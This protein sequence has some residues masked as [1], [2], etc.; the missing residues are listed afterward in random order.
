[1][2]NSELEQLQL[3]TE[4]DELI[5]RMSN[6]ADQ[7]TAWDPQRHC[8]TLI[9]RLLSRVE[10]LRIRL[11]APLLVAT[12]GGTGTGKSALVN[13]L[14]GQVCTPSGHERPTTTQP[15]LIA[16]PQTE[17]SSL[18]LPL[19][20]FH[21]K[22]IETPI[23]RDIVLLDCPDP[24]TSEG[25]TAGSNLAQL[26]AVLPMCDVLIY[27]STQ[28]KYRSARVV[29][30]LGQAAAGCRLLFVQTRADLDTDIRDDWKK[31]LAPHYEVPE[32]FFVDSLRALSEQQQGLRPS[33]DFGRLIDVLTT[34]L[35]SSQRIRIRRANLIDLLQ[36]AVE[37]CRSTLGDGIPAVRDLETALESQRTQLVERM[38]GRLKDELKT[39]RHLWERRLL[40]AVNELWGFS[41][42]SSILRL[43]HGLG[44]LIASMSLYRARTSAQMALLGAVQGVRWLGSRIKERDVEQQLGQIGQVGLDDNMLQES[45]LV[46][47]GYAHS[48]HMDRALVETDSLDHL[49][50]QAAK[51]EGQFLFDASRK[52]DDII[53]DLSRRNTGWFTRLRYE[54]LFL[55]FVGY[56]LY[57][58]GNNFFVVS[59]QDE[60]KILQTHFYVNAGVIFVIWS[61]VLIIL[62]MR[63]LRRGL[64]RH[65]E[66]LATEMAVS[67]LSKGLFPGLDRACVQSHQSLDQL[68]AVSMAIR[69][70]R[71]AI[72]LG[73]SLGGVQVEPSAAHKPA[74][75]VPQGNRHA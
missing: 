45:Q 70:L 69:R 38:S 20:N 46:I 13:A 65:I 16:H 44:S 48:A 22:T 24:D 19:E 74:V 9:K 67:R 10:T 3:L 2:S 51:V 71:D 15:V 7:P 64:D 33:G 32:V 73:K 47:E 41:P 42:F 40:G 50:E 34:Q 52:I 28:Q 14:V 4:V 6:W 29:D 37:H 21:I 53:D 35:G 31:Q 62:F 61:L 8:Q 23:L 43:Y 18:N 58:V 63:R 56:V 5:A 49:R 26:Q 54:V 11:E 30:E 59:F 39:S 72:T 27:T 66:T 68:E 60:S 75:A 12:F 1:M 25:A 55:A 36:G 57:R 17:L